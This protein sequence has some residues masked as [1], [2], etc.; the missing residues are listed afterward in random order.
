MK[1][2][3][4]IYIEFFGLPASGKTT[5]YNALTKELNKEKNIK[6]ISGSIEFLKLNKFSRHILP[7]LYKPLLT[8]KLFLFCNKFTKNKKNRNY[9]FKYFLIDNF[10]FSKNNFLYYLNNGPLHYAVSNDKDK[11]ISL[12]NNYPGNKIY[13]IFVNTSAEIIYKRRANRINKERKKKVVSKEN[14]LKDIKKIQAVFYYFKKNREKNKKIKDIIEINGDKSIAE[15]VE[16]LK[17]YL[18]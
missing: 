15:N 12:I 5:I 8:I 3:E 14:I 7:L 2:K 18:L 13:L 1:N 11:L 10:L 9:I 17:K 4:K 6:A 16:I